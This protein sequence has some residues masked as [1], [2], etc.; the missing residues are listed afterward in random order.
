VSDGHTSTAPAASRPEAQRPTDD[1]D[2][3]IVA[4]LSRGETRLAL[5]LSVERHALGI[6]RLCMAML[7]SQREADDL[8]E[9]TLLAAHRRFAELRG[10]GSVRAWL[11]GIARRECLS[12]LEK[13]RRRAPK[14]GRGEEGEAQPGA[15]AL[16]ALEKR[17]QSGRALL[18]RVRP[19]DRDAL[20]LRYGADL[21]F[22]EVAAASGIDEP[23]ARKRVSRAL[24][25]LRGV[26]ERQNDDD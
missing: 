15:G 24:S 12:Q 14:P 25:S 18:E 22:D 8:T 4:A 11:L 21:S 20:L 13:S 2:A 26:L 7:G 5:S 19:S 6:G 23:A 17:A 16:P 1:A 9:R 3:E 10:K